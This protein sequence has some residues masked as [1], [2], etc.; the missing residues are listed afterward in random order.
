MPTPKTLDL[1]PQEALE[2][3]T[4]LALPPQIIP[5]AG[6]R[7]K[8]QGSGRLDL[9]RAAV[10]KLALQVRGDQRGRGPGEGCSEHDP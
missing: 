2:L 3:P 1:T 9:R 8:S 4:A 5:E 10:T 7:K 6:R